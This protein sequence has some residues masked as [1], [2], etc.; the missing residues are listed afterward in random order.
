M[1]GKKADTHKLGAWE[2]DFPLPAA[3]SCARLTRDFTILTTLAALHN[4]C[5]KGV[6]LF[7]GQL[8]N[9]DDQYSTQSVSVLAAPLK[10]SSCHNLSH[11]LPPESFPTGDTRD[12]LALPQRGFNFIQC[13][14]PEVQQ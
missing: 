7:F 4:Q 9:Q 11:H 3:R 5:V 10:V 12:L 2:L 6:S 1:K 8:D 13:S 14:Q